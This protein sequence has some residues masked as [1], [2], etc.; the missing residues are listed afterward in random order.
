MQPGG[1]VGWRDARERELP[2]TERSESA[3]EPR[4]E[5]PAAAG[6]SEDREPSAAGRHTRYVAAEVNRSRVG[7]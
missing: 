5:Q 2:A 3:R 6:R 1:R 7:D 4:S